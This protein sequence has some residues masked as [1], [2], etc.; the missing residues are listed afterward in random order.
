[1]PTAQD[2]FLQGWQTFLDHL[3]ELD[4]WDAPT[5]KPLL[6]GRALAAA[7]GIKP[8]KWTGAA[9]NICAAWQL[10]NPG[11]TDPAGAIE[12]VRKQAKELE[13]PLKS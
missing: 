10:R 3:T 11:T 7:L 13:I 12:E 6:D 2:S 5:M 9:L 1:M 8:G 4:V